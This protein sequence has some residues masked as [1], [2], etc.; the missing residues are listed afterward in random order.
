MSSDAEENWLDF[1]CTLNSWEEPCMIWE[2]ISNLVMS[3]LVD[4][5]HLVSWCLVARTGILD[6]VLSSRVTLD[7]FLVLSRP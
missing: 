2:C 1:Q 5:G 7:K 3:S 6:H 4:F